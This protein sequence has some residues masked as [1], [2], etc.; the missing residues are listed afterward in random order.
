MS[1]RIRE[2]LDGKNNAAHDYVYSMTKLTGEYIDEH[3]TVKDNRTAAEI[4]SRVPKCCIGQ[5]PAPTI[6]E[7]CEKYKLKPA[8]KRDMSRIKQQ[9]RI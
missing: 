7:L 6:A 3:T 2:N 5:P 4:T 1:N 9:H 8:T